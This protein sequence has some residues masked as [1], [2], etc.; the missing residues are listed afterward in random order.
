M[1]PAI[2]SLLEV[3]VATTC[4]CLPALRLLLCRWL[5]SVFDIETP[6]HSSASRS[7]D[8]TAQS[9]SQLRYSRPI[10]K[11]GPSYNKHVV[12]DADDEFLATLDEMESSTTGT[13]IWINPKFDEA[14]NMV[15]E[16]ANNT[17]FLSSEAS[18]SMFC[19][20]GPRLSDGIPIEDFLRYRASIALSSMGESDIGTASVQPLTPTK[21]MKHASYKRLTS[22]EALRDDMSW[23][24][25]ASKTTASDRDRVPVS[26]IA[27]QPH[28]M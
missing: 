10:E 12:R 23:F 24:E 2:W 14:G 25:E 19:L 18:H 5:P 15:E 1:I 22:S 28:A 26:P 21:R 27:S 11:F 3:C 17:T 16:G 13:K 7:S 9:V 4:A 8:R 20:Q 6:C